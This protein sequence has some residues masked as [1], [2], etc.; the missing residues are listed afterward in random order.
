M[1]A[2]VHLKRGRGRFDGHPV[3]LGRL[4]VEF[5]SYRVA[6]D[7]RPVELTYHEFELLRLLVTS[8]DRVIP[9]E[10]IAGQLWG[11]SDRAAIRHLNVLVHRLRV[12]LGDTSPYQLTTVRGRGYGLLRKATDG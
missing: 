1:D 12:K 7:D 8:A 11:I 3:S 5:D 9:Y 6:V 4:S 10:T 2:D